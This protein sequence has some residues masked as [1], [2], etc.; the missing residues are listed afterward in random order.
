[1]YAKKVK[2]NN[3]AR[4]TNSKSKVGENT[5]YFPFVLKLNVFNLP[6]SECPIF[7]RHSQVKVPFGEKKTVSQQP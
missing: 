4:N 5:S 7:M 6:L 3:L 1:M 2:Y